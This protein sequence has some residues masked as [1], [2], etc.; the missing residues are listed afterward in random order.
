MDLKAAVKS[1]MW[2]VD[3]TKYQTTKTGLKYIILQPGDGP[4]A[5]SG[6]KVTVHYSGYLTDGK[7]FDSSV[8]R[9]EPFEFVLGVKMV[10]PGWDE[11]IALLS[12]GAKARFI[13][14]P[15]LAYGERQ[16]GKIPPN[17]QLVFDVQL[18][19]IK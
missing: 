10:I 6:K 13:I 1:K 7:P 8:E 17:S 18:L 14:P 16:V 12:K 19:D 4:K 5:D 15:S 11:G 2:D 9:D 3:S